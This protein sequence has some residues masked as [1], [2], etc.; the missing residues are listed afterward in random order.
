MIKIG[1]NGWMDENLP[2]AFTRALKV[3]RRSCR[4]FAEGYSWE[5]CTRQFLTLI[6]SNLSDPVAKPAPAEKRL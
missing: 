5:A 3:Y 2:T 1:S 6:Q 4:Q